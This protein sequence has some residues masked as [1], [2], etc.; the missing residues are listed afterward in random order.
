MKKLLFVALFASMGLGATTAM[1]DGWPLSV[2]G[3]WSVVANQSAGTLSI[4]S[5]G[6]GDCQPIKGTI[7]GNSIVGFYCPH[8]GRIHF[9][10]N[11]GATTIQDYTA[12]VS[13]AGPTLRMGG[14]FDSDL[15]A[16]GEYNFSGTK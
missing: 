6:L 8:S 2:L 11:N 5:Q 9:L 1:A 16:F 3:N 15:G 10:R 12:N 7:F 4:T 14:V 13:Q